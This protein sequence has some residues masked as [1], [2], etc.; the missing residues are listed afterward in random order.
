[1][2]DKPEPRKR[3]RK[4][5]PADLPRERIEY[6]LP[7]DETL[8]DYR[9]HLRQQ[10]SVPLLTDFKTWLDELAPKVLPQSLLGEAIG[11]CRRQWPYLIRYV[12]DGR[13]PLG[14]VEMWRGG[15]RPGLSVA[16]PFVW[17]CP[18]NLTIA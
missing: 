18:N 7:E 5:L 11:Y 3:G 12:D 1:E 2:L 6:D 15:S 8:T 10:H 9:Y 17:R 16:A 4:P 14:R 13:L